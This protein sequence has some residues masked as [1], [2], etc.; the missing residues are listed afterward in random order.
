MIARRS[1]KSIRAVC[2]YTRLLQCP[3]RSQRR[4]FRSSPHRLVVKPFLL[5]DIG[6]GIRECEVI[7]WF[8]EPDARVEQ[9]QKLC[10][11]QS[12]K[13]SVEI[14]SRFD[15]VIK[16]LHY[17]AGDMAI[18]GKPLVDIDIQSTISPEDEKLTAQ[19]DGE[20][21]VA[22]SGTQV[23]SPPEPGPSII[24]D[25]TGGGQEESVSE[26]RLATPAVRHLVKDMK[27]DI[28]TIRGTGKAGRILKED[29]YAHVSSRDAVSPAIATTE[30]N[31]SNLSSSETQ[32]ELSQIQMQMF[33][34]MTA[35]LSAPHFLFADE[36]N[37]TAL[38]SL[39]KRLAPDLIPLSTGA[40]T[41]GSP[42]D[43]DVKRQ[44][45]PSI[46]PFI[47]KAVS[48]SLMQHPLLNARL[49]VPAPPAKPT[50]T[51]RSAHNIGI[52]MATPHGLLVPVI[53][54]VGA[55][56]IAEISATLRTLQAKAA[57]GILTPA[58]LSGA[59]ISISN[60]GSIAGTYVAP[61]MVPGQVAILG[62]GRARAVPA[63]DE[64]DNIVK[65]R[66]ANFSWCADHRVVDGAAMAR[67][68]ET[69]RGFVEAPDRM[70]A[71]LR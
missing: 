15:G 67:M 3:N 1:E 34:S 66:V 55:R 69:V 18:V 35:S 68:A 6:E 44:R 40:S 21:D 37:L 30:Q 7:Q 58:D 63:F 59:T 12:D 54:D 27:L 51:L 45:D 10:E 61:L 53:H 19:L 36:Y 71:V 24:G 14:T 25:D 8:V 49:D 5:A 20:H 29:I 11:V 57:D 41:A 70:L 62:V 52:A 39:R 31:A 4:L 16:K 65:R 33:K 64:Q 13:A 23:T 22:I 56:S 9:F 50:L 48:Q 46:L 38:W 43:G 26:A 28:S 32:I 47:I 60:I 17:D 42:S 2:V